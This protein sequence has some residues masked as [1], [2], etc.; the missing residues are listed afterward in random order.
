[1]GITEDRQGYRP[2]HMRGRPR[3]MAA[4]PAPPSPADATPGPPEAERVPTAGRGRQLARVLAGGG[5]GRGRLLRAAAAVVGAATGLTAWQPAPAGAPPQESAAG[6]GASAVAKAAPRANRVALAGDSLVVLAAVN[7][8]DTTWADTDGKV[9]LGWQAEDAQPRLDR[10]V[11]GYG[12]SPEVL[13]VAFGHNDAAGPGGLTDEDRAQLAAL[14]ATPH[15]RACVVLVKPHDAGAGPARRLGIEAYRAWVDAA[16]ASR[17]DTVVVDWRPIA[18]AHP[19]YLATDGFHLAGSA[20]A[21]NRAYTD[22]LRAGA[23]ACD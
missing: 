16:A 17:E 1:M 3:H 13:V 20:P 19:E 6:T 10:D 18:L 23:R 8:G 21:G 5:A 2:R 15:E 14:V 4:D 9:G 11:R 12:T 22:M 7:G